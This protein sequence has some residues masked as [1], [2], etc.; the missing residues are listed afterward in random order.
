MPWFWLCCCYQQPV[1][2]S[3]SLQFGFL[4]IETV[5]VKCHLL[6]LHCSTCHSR[7]SNKM[8]FWGLKV[9][10][11]SVILQVF[12]FNSFFLPF[13]FFAK[14]YT[15]SLELCLVHQVNQELC[16]RVSGGFDSSGSLP[17]CVVGPC[18]TQEA[19]QEAGLSLCTSTHTSLGL[20]QLHLR[21]S[22]TCWSQRS[23]G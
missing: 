22:E 7:C 3:E 19:R 15:T 5:V 6:Q 12:F 2:Y 20:E 13:F 21:S 14:K 11:Q 10:F 23:A 18:G 1:Y 4:S 16:S 17:Y 8:M 9:W